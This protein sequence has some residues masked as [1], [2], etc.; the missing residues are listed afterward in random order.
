MSSSLAFRSQ[1]ACAVIIFSSVGLSYVVGNRQLN[2]APAFVGLMAAVC[3][4]IAAATIRWEHFD[5]RWMMILPVVD[6]ASIVLLS[7]SASFT[8]LGVLLIFPIIWM[9]ASFGL[10]GSVSGLGLAAVLLFTSALIRFLRPDAQNP[11][12]S[13]LGSL[14]SLLIM[15]G[16]TAA[17]I[18]VY[19]QR[20]SAERALLQRQTGL[21]EAALNAVRHQE[22]M[23]RQLLD[24][25]NFSVIQLRPDGRISLLNRASTQFLTRVGIPATS[26][27]DQLPIYHADR[28]TPLTVDELPHIRAQRGELSTD[29]IFWLGHPGNRRIA[30]SVNTRQLPGRHGEPGDIVMVCRDAT[31]GADAIQAQDD[32]VSSVSHELRT[33]LTSILGYVDLAREDPT[34]TAEVRAMLDVAFKNTNRLLSLVSKFLET[35]SRDATAGIKLERASC[36]LAEILAESIDSIR[37]QA[38]ERIIE[39]IV[40]PLPPAVLYADP[41][42]LRQVADNLLSNALK[43]NDFGGSITIG[44]SPMVGPSGSTDYEFHVTDTGRGLSAAEQKDLFQ[45]FYRAEA[46]RG[47]KIHGTGLGLSITKEIVELHHGT[48]RVHS[49]PGQGTTMTVRLPYTNE[50]RD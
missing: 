46:V 44:L 17:A 21:L 28:V 14:T 8:G 2:S 33:P 16:A 20:D 47:S 19:N 23:Q 24:S 10:L 9:A 38:A 30:L 22:H 13:E 40:A 3:A 18:H 37:P 39:L 4:S 27:L 32:L 48:I 36:D 31:A 5:Y 42:R 50:V 43:Y 26:R 6:I 11:S 29:E 45:K 35:A 49:K 41:L 34:V 25:V 1:M 7:T 12:V 15:L